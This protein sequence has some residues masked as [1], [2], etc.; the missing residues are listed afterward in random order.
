M[1]VWRTMRRDRA[2]RC[3]LRQVSFLLVAVL[4]SAPVCLLAQAQT[5]AQTQ[6]S[7]AV[8]RHGPL[9]LTE[10]ELPTGFVGLPFNTSVVA[11]G[12]SGDYSILTS[13]ELPA[14]I[15][16]VRGGGTISL[17]GIPTTSGEFRLRVGV[18]DVRQGGSANRV[19][20]FHIDPQPQATNPNFV[21]I[22]Q[23][24][25][26]HFSD[27]ASV[28]YP[29]RISDNEIFQLLDTPSVFMP[30]VIND[31]EAFKFKDTVGVFGPDKP[32]DADVFH[33]TDT[34]SIILS[35]MPRSAEV[36]H[37]TDTVSVS[38]KLG[39]SPSTAPAGANGVV[40]SQVFTVA[41]NT[42]A[43]TLTPSGALPSGLTFS[44]SGSSRTISGT[45]TQGGTFNFTLTAKDSLN[46]SSVN[47]A[48]F[49]A[50]AS[51]TITFPQPSSPV[52]Y[53]PGLTTTLTASSSAG[54]AYPVTYSVYGPAT[55]SGSTLTYTG[56]GTVVVTAMQAGDANFA[57]AA[58]VSVEILVQP[59][60]AQVFVADGNGAVSTLGGTSKRGTTATPGGGVG[61]AV[62]AQGFVWSINTNG[63]GLTRFTDTGTS[64]TTFT[65]SG[66]NGATSLAFDGNSILWITNA[67]GT[68]LSVSNAGAALSTSTNS[69]KK[70]SSAIAIDLSGN[71]WVAN[72]TTNTVDEVIGG[73]A[74]VAPLSTAVTSGTPGA[75]P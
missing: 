75:R 62:D 5:L 34:V 21:I 61:L 42:G 69:A 53:K 1:T 30:L 7:V 20:S 12:G 46:T 58:P 31:V 49:I 51:Q 48:L 71:I 10:G 72:P 55:V 19:Y 50:P 29:A 17:N 63:S 60:L 64:P 11:A 25:T 40:Y 70:A 33:F 43:A 28:F 67:D 4:L 57:S 8:A 65:P 56:T 23:A 15:S 16:L 74:P 66:M 6:Q 2:L 24:E 44:G 35:T 45:P 54:A 3:G 68:L 38:V 52:T 47:Y 37:F 26:F 36:F 59:N 18:T 32:M 13:G 9:A 14:G 39:V 41:G 22:N 73:A 27:T